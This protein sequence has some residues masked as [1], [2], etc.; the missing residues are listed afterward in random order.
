MIHLFEFFFSSILSKQCLKH[1]DYVIAEV[2]LKV[3]I[4]EN[5]SSCK[6]GTFAVKVSATFFK[7]NT[8][9]SH[10]CVHCAKGCNQALTVFGSVAQCSTNDKWSMV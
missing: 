5:N 6:N 9:I 3:Q 7:H 4:L 1:C 8:R 2:E 10:S